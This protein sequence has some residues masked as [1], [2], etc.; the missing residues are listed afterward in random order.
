VNR[1][2][3]I[4]EHSIDT[5]TLVSFAHPV[6]SD[7]SF[8]FKRSEESL[9]RTHTHYSNLKIDNLY[10]M[11]ACCNSHLITNP[12]FLSWFF[13]FFL[14]FSVRGLHLSFLFVLFPGST[15]LLIKSTWAIDAKLNNLCTLSTSRFA[16]K[17]HAGLHSKDVSLNTRKSHLYADRKGMCSFPPPNQVI[18]REHRLQSKKCHGKRFLQVD[19]I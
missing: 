13:V 16:Q 12:D 6:F 9:A 18:L 11:L 10:G 4:L 2:C 7:M 17:F 15:I 19:V 1:A 14:Y 5:C 8:C 3:R